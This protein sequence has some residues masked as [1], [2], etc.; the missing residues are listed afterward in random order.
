[1]AALAHPVEARETQHA[2]AFHH[3]GDAVDRDHFFTQSVAALFARVHLR[4]VQFRHKS[5]EF[6]PAGACSVGESLDTSVVSITGAVERHRLDAEL[7]RPLGNALAYLRGGFD[8]APVLDGLTHLGLD[9]RRGS[10]HLAARRIYYLRIDVAVRTMHR[11]PYRLELG[12][13]G[14]GLPRP[15][16]P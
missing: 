13:L 2:P 5:S 14:T 1:T 4:C 6:E 10:Q 8:I 9:R 11:E 3:L 7:L 15:A 16:Q 12:D